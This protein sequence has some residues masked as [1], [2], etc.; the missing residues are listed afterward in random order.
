MMSTP[1]LHLETE[2]TPEGT[3]IVVSGTIKD[4]TGVAL[5]AAE[6]TALTATLY[7]QRDPTKVVT[8]W[9]TRDVKGVGGGTF[10][11][12]KKFT[13]RIPPAAN[14]PFYPTY[15]G[16]VRVLLLEWTYNAGADAGLQQVH[17]PIRNLPHVGA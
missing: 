7:A 14:A 12:A 11:A 10:D 2:E 15:S 5:G 8:D 17:Y 6:L 9:D 4:E 16:E 1:W 3:T 13:L